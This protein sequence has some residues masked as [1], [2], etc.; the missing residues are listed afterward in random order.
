MQYISRYELAAYLASDVET[1][2]EISY[3]TIQ[4]PGI[5][6]RL[7]QVYPDPDTIP[8]YEAVPEIILTS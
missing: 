5:N 7:F 8:G 3:D 4:T 1:I 6:V 2:S